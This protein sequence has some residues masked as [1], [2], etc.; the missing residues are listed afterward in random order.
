[1]HRDVSSL[2]PPG[3][4]KKPS[5]FFEFFAYWVALVACGMSGCTER[6]AGTEDV[7]MLDVM[8]FGKRN[9]ATEEQG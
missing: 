2:A 7:M 5:D 8:R 1:M 3:N 6:Q 9:N 4:S